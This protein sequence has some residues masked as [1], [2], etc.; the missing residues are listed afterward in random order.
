MIVFLGLKWV[1]LLLR[2][3]QSKLRSL[4]IGK[5]HFHDTSHRQNG[6]CFA[7][8]HVS[9]IDLSV[10]LDN[11]LVDGHTIALVAF[12]QCGNLQKDLVSPLVPCVEHSPINDFGAIIFEDQELF[13][14]ENIRHV[15]REVDQ[16][17]FVYDNQNSVGCEV[18]L[19]RLCNMATCLY[20]RIFGFSKPVIIQMRSEDALS[21]FPSLSGSV[22]DGGS[23]IVALGSQLE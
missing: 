3:R 20:D 18:E 17:S 1:A 8:H 15:R 13:F 16:P 2:S 19:L 12:S 5:D 10:P 4:C 14:G 21:V 22:E 7:G 6:V 9:T 23:Y 11:G